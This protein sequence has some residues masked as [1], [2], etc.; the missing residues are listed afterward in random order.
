ME[1]FGQNRFNRVVTKADKAPSSLSAER[2][3][4]IVVDTAVEMPD[5]PDRHYPSIPLSL[6][7]THPSTLP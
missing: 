3:P 4:V 5:P 1:W 6:T 7:D 2:E